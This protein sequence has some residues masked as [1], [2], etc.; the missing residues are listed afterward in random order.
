MRVAEAVGRTLAALG[1]DHVFGV[2]GSGNFYVT[3]ALV[4]GGCRFVAARHEN[5]AAMMA[6]AFSRVTGR[7]SV[8]SLHQG[9]GLTNALTAVTESAKSHT[10]VLVVVGDTP[11]SQRTSNFWI[12]QAAVVDGLGVEVATVHSA[13]T[14]VDDAARAYHRAALGRRT[15]VLNLPL[16]IQDAE[17]SWSVADIP[18]ATEVIPPGPS[19]DAVRRVADMLAAAE[20]PLLLG[21]RGARH[22]A[23]AMERLA[24]TCGA[25]LAT[26]AVARGLFASNPWYL[27]VMG[28]FATPAA[29]ELTQSA[30]V[31]VAFGAGLNRWTTRNG[32]LIGASARVVQIDLDV[33]AIGFHRPVDVGVVGDTA[34]VAEAVAD[35]LVARGAAPSGWRNAQ[36]K[37]VIDAGCDWRVVP[38]RDVDEPGR[39]DPRT[40]TIDVDRRL[41]S[42]RIVVTDGGNFNGYPA[43]FLDVPDADGYCLPLAFQS[44]GLALPAGIGTA[45]AR[46]DRLTVV[47]VGDGGFMM[48]LTELD[49]AVRLELPLVVLV[50]NDDAY[51]AEVHHFAP[52]GEPVDIVRFPSTDIAAIAAGFGCSALTVRSVDDL[53]GLDRWLAASRRAPLVID[54]KIASFPS[55]VLAHTFA[56]E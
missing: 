55:W 22:A 13:R 27:D 52:D 47:G 20:R 11:P 41:P 45:L 30:D 16:D 2:V 40:F 9:C 38:Y 39:I 29:A 18:P 50:Y 53:A 8:V 35:R 26:S 7:V 4:V 21:G 24:D 36:T 46:P 19:P 54:A 6:D 28:G 12:D 37:E 31:I 33:D 14:A 3:N 42:E 23:G 10:P 48:S 17:C 51:G 5:G 15:V 43:M 49:T 34:E 1:A 25:L 44:I 56:D 32:T